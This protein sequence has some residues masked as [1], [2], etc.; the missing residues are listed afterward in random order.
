MFEK[1]LQIG[2]RK[3]LRQQIAIQ[4]VK[5][6]HKR[7]LKVISRKGKIK[8]AFF[9][10]NDSM[11]KYD[12]LYFLLKADERFEPIVFICPFTQYGETLMYEE[13]NRAF[14]NF[15][16]EG[17]SAVKTL[18]SDGTFMDVKVEFNP[19]LVFFTSP[20]DPTDPKYLINNFLDRLTCYVPYGFKSSN[21]FKQHFNLDMQMLCWKVFCE[22][23]FHKTLAKMHSSRNGDN[24]V[25]SGFPGIDNFIDNGYIPNEIWKVQTT[26]KKRII[27]A[28][29]HTVPGGANL[30]SYS[31]FL[32]YADV[33]LEIAQKY[34]D[35]LQFCFKPHPNLR[36]KLSMSTIWGKKKTDAYYDKWINLPNG[37]LEQGGYIDLFVD[38]DGMIHDSGSFLLEYFFV[39]RPVLFLIN[40]E[41]VK[42]EFNELGKK[43]LRC[44]DLGHNK[45]ELMN[46]IEEVLILGNDKTLP[47]RQKFVDD[48]LKPPN[49]KLASENIYDYLKEQ[50][51]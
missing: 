2:F 40:N 35:K 37:Q 48:Y 28:P 47:I 33:M 31:T 4:K 34:E 17:Y 25:V 23:Q 16:N 1:L 14:E 24:F 44:M 11:W 19:D 18:K 32:T 6:N 7:E 46:F 45:E 38:S 30:L 20:W 10:I 15:K 29:H 36:G 21:L 39:K 27:W 51:K 43:A 12:R 49:D 9:L 3:R 5:R 8:V 42:E 26:K 50:L 41:E 13:M 22:T